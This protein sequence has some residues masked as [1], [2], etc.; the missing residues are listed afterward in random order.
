[1]YDTIPV[2]LVSSIGNLRLIMA[3][4]HSYIRF[5]SDKQQWGDSERRQADQGENWAKRHGHK[6]SDL[7]FFD[8]GKSAFRGSKQK[9]LDAMLK[10][11]KDG[12]IR[13]GDIL[14][15]EAIDRLSRKGIRAT[16]T[17]VNS[18]LDAGVSI[19]ILTPVEK[20]YRASDTNDIGGA[21]ELAAFSY[22]AFAY[23]QNLSYRIKSRNDVVRQK[24]RNGDK[25]LISSNLA[26][27]LEKDESGKVSIIEEKAAIVRLILKKIIEGYGAHRL[28]DYLNEKGIKP[29][30]RSDTWNQTF[31]RK[32]VRERTIIGEYQPHIIDDEGKR[33]PTGE[34]IRNY[35]PAVT[36]EATWLKANNSIDNRVIERGPSSLFCNIFSGITHFAD[37]DCPAHIYTYQQKR[38]DGRK[39][40]I[41]RLMSWKARCKVKGANRCTIDLPAFERAML[42]S[43]K[44]IELAADTTNPAIA[45]LN[46]KTAELIKIKKRIAEIQKVVESGDEDVSLLLG[47]LRN[48]QSQRTTLET[49][50][51]ELGSKAT[52]SNDLS[53]VKQLADLELTPENRQR[54]REALKQSIEAIHLLP[55]KLGTMKRSPI[56]AAVEIKFNCGQYRYVYLFNGKHKTWKEQSEGCHINLT[57]MT[58]KQL[59]SY[60]KSLEKYI[61]VW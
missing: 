14:L 29:I 23:S 35:F 45:M 15:V 24:A 18:I 58:S 2:G 31:L 40:I 11:I 4:I 17:L 61:Q 30:G 51:R 47:S 38:A 25:V 59:G 28:T 46:T 42:S 26:G 49:Q 12:R 6:F 41:R 10:A 44:E 27:W 3:V 50:V 21:I 48:L 19:A 8:S 33:V 9:M 53:G 56:A 60:K 39:V 20:V 34:P 22:Q 54:L 7:R 5:S 16:Q 13:A 57:G 43:L 55:I 52:G 37:D 36:D 32:L 1:M